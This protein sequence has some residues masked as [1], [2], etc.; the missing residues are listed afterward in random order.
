[1][2]IMSI[3]KYFSGNKQEDLAKGLAKTKQSFWTKLNKALV[4]RSTVDDAVL[5]ELE[6]LLIGADVGVETTIKIIQQLEKRVA[7]NKYLH[8]AEIQGILQEIIT[9][10]ISIP[11][12]AQPLTTK[13]HV[14]F[15]V[16]VNGVGKTTT[17]GK[18]AFHYQQAGKKVILG[19][20]D[21]F[22][23]AATNQLQEWGKRTA[24]PVIARGR[25]ADP[26]AV[27]YD[28]VQAGIHEKA[29]IVIIDT[30]GRLHN[31]ISL[32]H[33]LTKIKRTI[34]KLIE[35]APQEVLL[36]LDATTGQNA[37]AQTKAFMEATAINALAVTKL[38]GTA[39]GG[40]VLGISAQFQVPVKYI[41]VGEQITDLQLFDKKAFVSTLFQK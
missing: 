35:G 41:G 37:F 30:A 17:I 38:D 19:A 5:D 32:M 26:A 15:V 33:E 20:A 7:S 34:A 23:A 1:M 27:A 31:K 14:I 3:F 10:L 36:V 6:E 9:E 25:H 2:A 4:G 24:I 21:T 13:P 12:P 40:V 8:V 28:A 39:K 18:L 16:G 22:R 29:D 11:N